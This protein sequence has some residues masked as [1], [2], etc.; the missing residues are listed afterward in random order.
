[1]TTLLAFSLRNSRCNSTFSK[2]V[3]PKEFLTLAIKREENNTENFAALANYQEL[4]ENYIRSKKLNIL[5]WYLADILEVS[6]DPNFIK[7]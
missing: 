1:M 7:N 4:I 2:C 3:W 5:P 6:R